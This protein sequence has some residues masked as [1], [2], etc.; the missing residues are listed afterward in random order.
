MSHPGNLPTDKTIS[1]FYPN[2]T[3]STML[4]GI[5]AYPGISRFPIESSGITT[6]IGMSDLRVLSL[7][8]KGTYPQE[9]LAR[10]EPGYSFMS[11]IL[12][13][14][15][16]TLARKGPSPLILQTKSALAFSNRLVFFKVMLDHPY[17]NFWILLFFIL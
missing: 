1:G 7:S 4:V 3:S 13:S 2:L 10:T 14:W 15:L 12:I 6:K 8:R 16:S 11:S 5:K 9:Y 17:T